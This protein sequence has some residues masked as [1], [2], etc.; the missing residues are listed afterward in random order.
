MEAISWENP[1]KWQELPVLPSVHAYCYSSKSNKAHD[2]MQNMLVL[3]VKT[4]MKYI[5]I[6][7]IKQID[8]GGS[9]KCGLGFGVAFVA[10]ARGS[11]VP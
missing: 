4:Y 10:S 6:R 1:P 2:P 11:S 9:K 3:V 5:S 7:K 8:I